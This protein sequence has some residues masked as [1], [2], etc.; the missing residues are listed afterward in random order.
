MK[1]NVFLIVD[2][3]M[4]TLAVPAYDEDFQRCLRKL[5]GNVKKHENRNQLNKEITAYLEGNKDEKNGE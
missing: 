5:V 2:T 3:Q 1:D 4:N